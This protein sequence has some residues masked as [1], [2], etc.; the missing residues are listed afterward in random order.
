MKRSGSPWLRALTAVCLLL[1]GIAC[2]GDPGD[3]VDRLRARYSATLGSFVVRDDPASGRQEILLDVLV[4]WDGRE[5]LPG[6]TLDLTMADA[7]GREKGA[8]KLWVDTAGLD[9]GP[10]RQLTLT[11]DD[12]PYQ[13]GDGFFVEVRVP[14]PPAER[15]DYREFSGGR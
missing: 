10:G 11:V 14:I 4:Q 12:L 2:G 7:A 6:L 5:P 3:R 8:R 13:A 15:G 9:R 1:A